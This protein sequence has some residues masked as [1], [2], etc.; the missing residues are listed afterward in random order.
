MREIIVKQFHC[1]VV[2]SAVEASVIEGEEK[3]RAAS[4][5]QLLVSRLLRFRLVKV[6]YGDLIE[7]YRAIYAPGHTPDSMACFKDGVPF[8]VDSIV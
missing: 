6:N 5:L 3:P 8:S 2:V 4:F 7:E 1:N